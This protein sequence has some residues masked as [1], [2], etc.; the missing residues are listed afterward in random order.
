M[1][2]QETVKPVV[3]FCVPVYNNAH[4]ALE[5]VKSL[6]SSDDSR[7]EVVVSDD[8]SRENV[9][10]VLSVIH[11]SRFRYC[12]NTENIGAHRNWERSLELGRGEWLYLIMA[13]DRVHG[14]NISRLI[15]ILDYARENG[16]TYL[17]D[18]Y[19]DC[20]GKRLFLYSGMNAMIE[21]LR[22]L[23]PTG[24]IYSAE[25]FRN[26]P[27]RTR[28]YEISDMYPENYVKH[29]LLLKGRGAYI[30]SNVYVSETYSQLIDFTKIKSGV[31]SGGD[32]FSVYFSPCRRTI[33]NLEIIDTIDGDSDTFHQYELD[34]FFKSR[35]NSIMD[36]ASGI[37][38]MWCAD[39]LWM[40]HY[41]HAT[42][43]VSIREIVSNIL[44]SSKYVKSHLQQQG[45]LSKHRM[46]IIRISCA[47]SIVKWTLYYPFKNIVRNILKP[48]GVWDFLKRISGRKS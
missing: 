9:E 5:I 30:D 26:I 6:L 42:R 46:W 17:K 28:Y 35:F 45:T 18:G 13:R 20:G 33:Q 12:R 2:A 14:E 11:D 44:S 10:E 36:Y 38:K 7:F 41:G 25:I 47:K 43:Y 19:K 8:N 22:V 16:I 39:S 40:S 32:V 3:S 29:H 21:F 34:T 4:A 27:C 37:W 24:D 48:L 15:D 31:E 1:N 23:H